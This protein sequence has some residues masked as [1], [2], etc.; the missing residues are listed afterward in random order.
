MIMFDCFQVKSL[1]Q[2]VSG[3]AE[4][5]KCLWATKF[6]IGGNTGWATAAEVARYE[7]KLAHLNTELERRKELGR[8][9]LTVMQQL[10]DIAT[11]D[12][13]SREEHQ[14]CCQILVSIVVDTNVQCIVQC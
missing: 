9:Y 4:S 10:K 5:L 7:A 12:E 3:E 6:H 1:Y 2:K 14:V 8:N 11:K 13:Q